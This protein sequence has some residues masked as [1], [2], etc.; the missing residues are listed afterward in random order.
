M[1]LGEMP[2]HAVL[3]MLAVFHVFHLSSCLNATPRGLSICLAGTF[4][5]FAGP[6]LSLSRANCSACNGSKQN[7][8]SG[9][10]NRHHS[11]SRRSRRSRVGM[12]VMVGRRAK[13]TVRRLP[14]LL[15]LS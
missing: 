2:L 3:E 7:M 12:V 4:P 13:S 6:A 15:L 14:A 8:R 11:R 10:S 1:L 9:R 5:V